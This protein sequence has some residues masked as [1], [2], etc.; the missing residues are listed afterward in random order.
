MSY[1]SLEEAWGSD[2]QRNSEMNRNYFQNIHN[3]ENEKKNSELKSKSNYIPYNVSL[4]D[5]SQRNFIESS[6]I[7]NT[8]IDDEESTIDTL[9]DSEEDIRHLDRER[10]SNSDETYLSSK[11]YFLYKKYQKLA[12]KYKNRLLRKYKNIKKDDII[13]GFSSPPTDTDISGE[14]RLNDLLIFVIF[15][16]FIIFILDTFVKLGKKMNK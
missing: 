3:E 15:G 2:F 10:D 16:V 7:L 12:L 6:N 9:E 4:P 5:S 14:K 13:E 1:C 11:D 8:K